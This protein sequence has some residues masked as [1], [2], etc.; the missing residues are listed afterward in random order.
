MIKLFCG[1]K[2]IE[3]EEEFSSD[4]IDYYDDEEDLEETKEYKVEDFV[5]VND[6]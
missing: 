1:D 4:K 6:E 5:E 3:V 2:E